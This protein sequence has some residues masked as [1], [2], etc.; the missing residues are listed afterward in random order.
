VFVIRSQIPGLP[1]GTIF[2]GAAN[3]LVAD[4]LLLVLLVAFP[5]LALWLPARLGL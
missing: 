5:A 3:F 2:R 1:L 4:A